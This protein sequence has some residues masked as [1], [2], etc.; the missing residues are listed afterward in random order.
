MPGAVQPVGASVRGSAGLVLCLAIA[1][2]A[3]AHATS[4]QIQS[5]K[6]LDQM[7]I[8]ALL[9][10]DIAAVGFSRH[11]LPRGKPPMKL[12]PA[13]QIKNLRSLHQAVRDHG[14]GVPR[15]GRLQITALHFTSHSIV[16]DFNGGI[17]TTHWYNH[18]QFGMGGGMNAIPKTA[19]T[20]QG[21]R[22]ILK[23][24]A[25]VPD[26]NAAGLKKYLNSVVD[27]NQQ[28][29]AAVTTYHLP[30][31][32]RHAIESHTAMVGMNRG[33][34]VAALG[35]TQEKYH[36]QNP[37]TGEEYTVWVFGRPPQNTTFVKFEGGQVTQ[38]TTYEANGTRVTHT[39]PQ[40]VMVGDRHVTRAANRPSVGAGQSASQSSA[41]QARPSLHRHPARYDNGNAASQQASPVLG[42]A[43]NGTSVA[44]MGS[45]DMSTPPM[46]APPGMPS[47][48]MPDSNPAGAGPPP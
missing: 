11:N 34:I 12:N 44:P 7:G 25:G 40:I 9:R 6:K 39:H 21:A 33:M 26:M 32:V 3:S 16:V 41:S 4:P 23:F 38:I 31:M 19:N 13:G 14:I 20:V 28:S 48:G 2:L 43:Q 10:G 24:P 36:E 18:L 45:P 29:G 5:H 22:A 17:H 15:G 30:P 1:A 27:W 47:A 37:Q 42:P 8:I 46:A 35:R